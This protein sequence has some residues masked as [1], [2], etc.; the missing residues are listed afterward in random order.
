TMRSA[1][2]IREGVQ[3]PPALASSNPPDS[4]LQIELVSKTAEYK[5]VPSSGSA[6]NRTPTQVDLELLIR[7]IGSR[8]VVVELDSLLGLFLVGPGAINESWSVQIGE[9]DKE[10]NETHLAP[11]QCCRIPITSFS[12]RGANSSWLLPG[13]YSIYAEY[14][15]R[16]TY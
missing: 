11:N 9:E 13:E 6:F 8:E 5:L 3:N 4:P 10:K 12:R 1:Q 7:N 16:R 15:T 14:F 2:S